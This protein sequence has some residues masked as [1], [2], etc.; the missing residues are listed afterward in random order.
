MKKLLKSLA[1]RAL[2]VT[3]LHRVALKDTGVIVAFHRVD[4]RN[5]GDALT[6]SVEAFERFCHFFKRYYEVIPLGDLVTRLERVRS[7]EGSLVITFDD[8]FRDFY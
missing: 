1:G 5:A 6:V 2:H 8:G 3:G 4:D 7:V